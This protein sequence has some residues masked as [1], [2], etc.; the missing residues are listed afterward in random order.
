MLKELIKSKVPT[1]DQVPF[2]QKVAYGLGGPVEGTANWVPSQNLTP[3]FN[4]A[5][6]MNPALLGLVLMIWRIYDAV[7]DQVMGNFSDNAR[8]QWGRRRPF[9]VLGAILTGIFMPLIW[10]MPR[11]LPEWQMVAWLLIAGILFYT[12]FTIWSMPYYS[13]QLEMSPNYNERTNITAYRAF[14][15]QIFSLAAGWILA[16]AALP[17]F[18][19][20][21][22]GG[23][24]LANGM[25]YVSIGLGI[26][27]IGLGVLPGLFVKERYYEKEA[28]NQAKQPLIGGLKQTLT[29]RPFLWLLVIVI[30]NSF[31]FGLV[32]SLG[33]YLNAYYVC[34]GDLVKA[35]TI[36]GV[37]STAIFAP[38]LIAIPLC[39]WIANRWDK[40]TLLYITVAT[41]ML[42]SIS[43]IFFVTP[44][45]PWLQIIPPLLIGPIGMGLWLVA[46]S[47]QADVADFDELTTGK[48]R[49]GSFA[50]TFSW[51]LKASNA[52]AGGLS[53][54]VIVG[55]GFAIERGAEQAPNVLENI[56]LFYIGIPLFFLALCLF[57]I[58]RYTL[59]RERMQDIRK[60]L[61]SR[62][63]VI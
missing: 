42:G 14:A 47:M 28:K 20:A 30:T 58:S 39:T 33:F 48:R 44:S 15:Q 41:G 29:T 10:W 56:K 38:N 34:Q 43:V 11:D 4:I 1:K 12:C 25:R 2:W 19:L 13:L 35:T 46:P 21:P 18:S 23:P 45:N 40:R 27:T 17:L 22:D 60:E 50:A 8:T 61:E 16:L 6:G 59:T 57:A 26:L 54:L 32:G 37:I 9:I 36:A 31:G 63:G 49:E 7:S 5:M 51:T 3:V 62:R 52:V 53:G 55:T 24:D